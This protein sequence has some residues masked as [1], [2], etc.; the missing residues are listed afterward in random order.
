MMLQKRTR[1]GSAVE[2][3]I[4]LPFIVLFVYALVQTS[5]VYYTHITLNQVVTDTSAKVATL[6]RRNFAFPLDSPMTENQVVAEIKNAIRRE[7]QA[8][9]GADFFN[10]LDAVGGLT[11][12]YM[13]LSNNSA[14]TYNG[15][16][17]L[18]MDN[19]IVNQGNNT[20][21]REI[22]QY[23]A[24]DPEYSAF[25]ANCSGLLPFATGAEPVIKPMFFRPYEITIRFS[26]PI[27]I[28]IFG[29]NVDF[30]LAAESTNVLKDDLTLEEICPGTWSP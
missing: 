4:A 26:K 14:G 24:I 1:I 13:D 21:A 11:I 7:N 16:I 30:T 22:I 25:L 23:R 6:L 28:N 3:A 15:A 2:L 17:T 27:T 9:L 12:T 5:K 10:F 20:F 8:A 29:A 19:G 18:Y